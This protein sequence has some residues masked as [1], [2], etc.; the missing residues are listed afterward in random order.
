M[1]VNVVGLCWHYYFLEKGTKVKKPELDVN[2][3]EI[4]V[5]DIESCED[6]VF[7]AGKHDQTL[8]SRPG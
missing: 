8:H 5:M 6:E 3:D 7:G 2:R 4:H 1:S